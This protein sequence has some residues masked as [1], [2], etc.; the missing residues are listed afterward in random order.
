MSGLMLGC[1]RRAN[2]T[3]KGNSVDSLQ[4]AVESYLPIAL[5][6]AV[7]PH[8]TFVRFDEDKKLERG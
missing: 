3:L 6:G 8:D 1:R 4:P 5:G 2:A 7:R